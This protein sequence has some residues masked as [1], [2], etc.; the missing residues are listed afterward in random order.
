M[1]PNNWY[2]ES[3]PFQVTLLPSVQMFGLLHLFGGH[4]PRPQHMKDV[5][6]LMG[7]VQGKV[8]APPTKPFKSLA[9]TKRP[10][11]VDVSMLSVIKF[12]TSHLPF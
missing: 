1:L 3:N 10:A 8:T 4:F 9:D 7:Y 5:P 12:L 6:S 2:L 11:N